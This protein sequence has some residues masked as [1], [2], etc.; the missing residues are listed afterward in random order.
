MVLKLLQV[1]E[2]PGRSQVMSPSRAS[3]TSLKTTQNFDVKW[4]IDRTF[5]DPFEQSDMKI[6][7]FKVLSDPNCKQMV[8]EQF[9]GEQ[10]SSTTKDVSSMV[11]TKTKETADPYLSTEVNDAAV[12]GVC[13]LSFQR[14]TVPGN[15]GYLV[16][17]GSERVTC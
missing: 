8:Q 11:L 13:H 4:L 14:F 1:T 12:I 9:M 3:S 7:S 6:W 10:E 15:Q 5:A 17:P 2:E 16:H